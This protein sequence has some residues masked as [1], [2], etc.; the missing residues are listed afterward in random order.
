[1]AAGLA[2]TGRRTP[3]ERSDLL[4]QDAPDD[5]FAAIMKKLP[6]R[7]EAVSKTV[8][9]LAAPLQ[10]NC[11]RS[12]TELD[13]LFPDRLE[14]KRRIARIALIATIIIIMVA[15]IAF[16]NQIGVPILNWIMDLIL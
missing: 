16:S 14:E 7:V 13:I 1:M 12:P 11:Y 9:A 2:G 5:L 3:T 8:D 10:S 15:G 6:D 4:L